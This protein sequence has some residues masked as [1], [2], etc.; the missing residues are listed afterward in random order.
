MAQVPLERHL[1]HDHKKSILR[2]S[3]IWPI[4]ITGHATDA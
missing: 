3:T 1:R 4:N 2:L